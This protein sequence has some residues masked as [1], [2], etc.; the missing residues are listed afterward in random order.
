MA[1]HGWQLPDYIAF[2]RPAAAV[3]PAQPAVSIVIPAYNEAARIEPY[4]REVAALFA[5]RQERCEILV[6]NDGSSDATPDAIRA[7]MRQLPSLGLLTYAQNRGKGHAVRV[8]MLAA[9]GALRAFA[10]ADGST[11]IAELGKL[12]A[13]IE[14]DGCDVAIGSRAW[15][16]TST[17]VTVSFH[18]RAI[19]QGFRWVRNVLLPLGVADSQCG[20]KLFTEQAAAALFPVS[21]LNGF[22]FDVELLYLARR[23]GLKVAEVPVNWHES[24]DSHIRLWRDPFKMFLDVLRVRRL[25]RDL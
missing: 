6:V 2:E 5:A 4:L 16:E 23:K 10:D 8:G 14:S 17:R 15:R 1:E 22:A 19:A 7:L 25:H 20:F 18:R 21:R 12:R 24:S 3:E 11:P 13:R 9:R